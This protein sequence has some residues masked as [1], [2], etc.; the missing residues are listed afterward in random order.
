MDI[1]VLG[2]GCA[3]CVAVDKLVKEALEEL[4]MDATM[5]K[6]KD[7]KKFAKYGV[8][9]TPALVIDSQVKCAGKIPTKAEFIS[10]LKK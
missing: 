6:V 4:K 2:P 1:K 5:E 9:S 8:F 7:I 10:L 3:R